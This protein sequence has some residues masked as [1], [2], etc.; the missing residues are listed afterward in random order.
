[1][2]GIEVIAKERAEQLSKH[3]YTIGKDFKFNDDGQ[4]RQGALFLLTEDYGSSVPKC[5]DEDIFKK[6]KNKSL[7]DRLAIAGALIAAEIDRLNHYK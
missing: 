6:M 2:T 3:H 4:L 1:M 7:K 5:W